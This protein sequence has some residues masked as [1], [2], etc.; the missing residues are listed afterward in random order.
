MGAA[1]STSPVTAVERFVAKFRTEVTNLVSH[2]VAIG[3]AY[4]LIAHTDWTKLQNVLT[5]A[6]AIGAGGLVNKVRNSGKD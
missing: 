2:A 5:G 3:G 1:E 4:V 6:A